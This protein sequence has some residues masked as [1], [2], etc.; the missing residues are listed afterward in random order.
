M[1]A[2]VGRQKSSVD[3]KMEG[4]TEHVQPITSNYDGTIFPV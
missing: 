3:V 1:A 4:H 2:A